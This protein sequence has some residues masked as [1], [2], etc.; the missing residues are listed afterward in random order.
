MEID[1]GGGGHGGGDLRLV[2]DFVHALQGK[3]RSISCTDLEDS[4][5]GHLI[6]F[7]ADRARVEHNCVEIVD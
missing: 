4:I 7:A 3:P 6:G 2:A 1:A 5:F